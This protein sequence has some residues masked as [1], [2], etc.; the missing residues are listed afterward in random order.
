MATTYAAYDDQAIWGTGD[1]PE[2]ALTDAARWV[3][4][5]D[6][7][8]LVA[9]CRTATMTPELE[10][11]VAYYGGNTGFGLL[12]DGILGTNDQLFAQI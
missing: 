4:A 12:A 7:E 8:K 11:H 3:N 10:Q 6:A 2:A 5:E 1:T 9:G